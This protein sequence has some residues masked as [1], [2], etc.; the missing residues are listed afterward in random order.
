MIRDPSSPTVRVKDLRGGDKDN[1]AQ[2]DVPVQ[3]L[4][5]VLDYFK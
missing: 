2:V 1:R 3:D 4:A 5:R